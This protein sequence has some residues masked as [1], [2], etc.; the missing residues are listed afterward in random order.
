MAVSLARRGTNLP[1]LM[2]L[3]TR[4]AQDTPQLDEPRAKLVLSKIDSILAR[5]AS[6]EADREAMYVELGQCLCEVRLGQYWRLE[7]LKS[8]DDFIARRF[9]GSGRKAYYF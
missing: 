1:G 4:S 6:Q 2:S 7:G 8:F 5:E 9:P 3:N